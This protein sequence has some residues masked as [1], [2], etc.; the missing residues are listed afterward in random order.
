M[1]LNA[2]TDWALILSGFTAFLAFLIGGFSY[3]LKHA[4]AKIMEE[5]IKPHLAQLQNNGGKSLKDTVDKTWAAIQT[6][7]LTDG[8]NEA[9]L[10]A[11]ENN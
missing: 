3:V 6:L 8:E 2:W 7:T 5:E 9:R 1:N 4:I 11:L 10:N